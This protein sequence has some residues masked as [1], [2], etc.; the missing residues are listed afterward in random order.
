MIQKNKTRTEIF[1]IDNSLMNMVGHY[2]EYARVL[3][4]EAQHRGDKFFIL[5]HRNAANVPMNQ[6]PVEPVFR[7]AF[8]HVFTSRRV[9]R[10]ANPLIANFQFYRD[11]SSAINKRVNKQTVLFMPT[12]TH[13]HLFAWVWW[14]IQQPLLRR[15][16]VF[17]LFRRN[18][19]DR[20]S[21]KWRPETFWT[22]LGFKLIEKSDSGKIFH[23]A[24]DS[25][26]LAKEYEYLTRLP[27]DIFPIPHTRNVDGE[28]I[29]QKDRSSNK[30]RPKLRMVSLGDARSEKGF[31]VL[32][33]ALQ[34]LI[35]ELESHQIEVVLQCNING[36]DSEAMNAR[37]KLEEIPLPAVSLITE[38][39]ST[40]G[41][42]HLLEMS[43][44]ILLPYRRNEYY[45]R[46]SGILA[47]AIAAGKPVVTTA[48]TWMAEQILSHKGSGAL[49]KDGDP[50]DIVRAIRE[51]ILQYEVFRQSAEHHK[52]EWLKF[53]NPKNLYDMIASEAQ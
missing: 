1:L 17:L 44:I 26:R 47:E 34:K 7:H 46:S 10:L 51:I 31:P 52:K 27:I 16:K 30:G 8:G 33:N 13:Q 39:L 6:L 29:F 38:P 4:E 19:F 49:A 21:K 20:T 35:P 43:H 36:M 48:D 42:Y 24:T 50:A 3:F 37:K 32:V 45:A 23:F 2:Y 28:K 25:N 11:V 40:E 53:H 41:Y 22:R 14:S 15:P 18:L 5:G 9:L 12:V